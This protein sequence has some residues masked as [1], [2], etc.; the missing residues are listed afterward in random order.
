M[1]FELKLLEYSERSL[2]SANL[3]TIRLVII[4]AGHPASGT[5]S[6]T[7]HWTVQVMRRDATVRSAMDWFRTLNID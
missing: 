5:E 7:R 1:M 4:R 3:Q 6:D 2:K